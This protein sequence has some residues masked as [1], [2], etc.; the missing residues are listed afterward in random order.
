MP[1]GESRGSENGWFGQAANWLNIAHSTSRGGSD[2]GCAHTDRFKVAGD[3]SSLRKPFSI[4]DSWGHPRAIVVW[5]SNIS[6]STDLSNDCSHG[7][8]GCQTVC[9]SDSQC[10]KCA[11]RTSI[12]S[13]VWPEMRSSRHEPL[14]VR[15]ALRMR[16]FRRV[17]EGHDLARGWGG[18][19]RFVT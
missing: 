1:P 5:G 8:G 18:A 7:G 9:T 15:T 3:A 12:I 17:D 16:R 14:V 6:A 2:G 4:Y 10:A 11:C 13:T 19:R